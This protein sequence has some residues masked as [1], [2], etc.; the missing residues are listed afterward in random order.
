MI[1]WRYKRSD[2]PSFL[3]LIFVQVR[4]SKKRVTHKA[5]SNIVIVL[6]IAGKPSCL[7]KNARDRVKI[8]LLSNSF[9][10]LFD[11]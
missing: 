11:I 4:K 2:L 9:G 5:F 6:I 7:W 10:E 3:V 1:L 8:N